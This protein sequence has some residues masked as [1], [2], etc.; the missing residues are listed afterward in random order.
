MMWPCGSTLNLP[1]DVLEAART[2]AHREE[3]SLAEA[4]VVLAR[5][6]IS[7]PGIRHRADGFPVFDVPA[8]G[9]TITL[10]GVQRSLDD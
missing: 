7:S 8:G 9:R 3:I 5:R 6:G 10:E 2:I 1:D 4:V